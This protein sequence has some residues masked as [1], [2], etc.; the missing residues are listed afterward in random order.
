MAQKVYRQ[1]KTILF[2]MVFIFHDPSSMNV[3]GQVVL[4][5]LCVI[6]ACYYEALLKGSDGSIPYRQTTGS[7]LQTCSLVFLVYLLHL[8]NTG[9]CNLNGGCCFLRSLSVFV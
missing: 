7:S 3:N 5:G 4:F 9:H 6:H 8:S 2:V 1:R